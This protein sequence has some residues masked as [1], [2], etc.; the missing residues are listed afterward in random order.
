MDL[1]NFLVFDKNNAA[2]IIDI[3]YLETMRRFGKYDGKKYTF[4]KGVFNDDEVSAA[5]RLASFLRI[6]PSVAYNRESFLAEVLRR[7][8]ELADTSPAI[9]EKLLNLL[10]H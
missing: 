8:N 10:S 3:G 4:I 6:N 1:G 9:I 2:R 5:D 7:L